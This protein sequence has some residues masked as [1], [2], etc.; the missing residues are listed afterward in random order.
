MRVLKF[1]LNRIFVSGIL[2][3]YEN[4][5]ITK[6]DGCLSVRPDGGSH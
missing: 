6:L 2:S 1:G 5:C 4:H 3:H